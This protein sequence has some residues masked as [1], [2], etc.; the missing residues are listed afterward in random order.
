M[1]IEN[2]VNLFNGK[3]LIK[4][5]D[6]E[7]VE[8][9]AELFHSG[10]LSIVALRKIRYTIPEGHFENQFGMNIDEFIETLMPELLPENYVL[11]FVKYD[12]DGGI[13]DASELCHTEYFVYASDIET[14]FV[15]DFVDI[16]T[17]LFGGG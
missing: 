12:T 17:L 7:S 15:P 13:F 4:K 2:I 16:E 11:G 5:E 10:K 9:L 14:M 3:T 1:K 8:K 6:I